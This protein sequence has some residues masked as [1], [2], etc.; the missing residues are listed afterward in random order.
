MENCHELEAFIAS[1]VEVNVRWILEARD[2][3]P[4]PIEKLYLWSAPEHCDIT[5]VLIEGN[6][7]RYEIMHG[8]VPETSMP[9]DGEEE[10]ELLLDFCEEHDIDPDDLYWGDYA[11]LPEALYRMETVTAA[12]KVAEQLK[13]AGIAF[14][15][16]AEIGILIDDEDYCDADSFRGSV[17]E[18]LSALPSEAQQ[19]FL[20]LYYRKPVD[21]L[22]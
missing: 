18:G 15:A 8:E 6:G 20:G 19:P 14:T 4:T 13:E 17:E 16:D 5:G 22:P 12:H 9:L 1:T 3:L 11:E 2:A 7:E 10:D 21:F